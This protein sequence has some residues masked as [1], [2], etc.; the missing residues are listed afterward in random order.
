MHTRLL[1]EI[2]LEPAYLVRAN[3][4]RRASVAVTVNIALPPR[5]GDLILM[6]AELAKPIP[7]YLVY[8]KAVVDAAQCLLQRR[9]DRRAR[10]DD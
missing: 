4:A 8:S 9:L 7:Y 10:P 3:A 1:H 6:N 5:S 2:L